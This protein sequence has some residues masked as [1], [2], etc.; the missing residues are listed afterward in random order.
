MPEIGDRCPRRA[1][2]GRFTPRNRIGPK[3]LTED[4]GHPKLREHLASVT[5]IMRLSNHYDDFEVKLD[6]IHP[7]YDTT[8]SLPFC[9]EAAN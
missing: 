8:L 5:T 3:R 2:S 9:D 6:L 4:L 7:R 1:A